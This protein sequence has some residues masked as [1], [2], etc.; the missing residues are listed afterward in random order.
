L[1]SITLVLLPGLEGS[2]ALFANLLPELPKDLKV[3]VRGYP[4][5]E[6]LSYPQLVAWLADIVPKDGPYVLL[7]ES[8]GSP[9]AVMFAATHPPN[10]AGIILSAGFISNPVRRLGILPNLLANPIFS[11]L[12]PPDFAIK[13]FIAGTH[14]P[15]SLLQA[16]RNAQSA[17]NPTVFAKRAQAT[18]HCDA[19][20]EILRVNVPLLYLQGT[21]DHLVHKSALAEIERLHPQTISVPIRAPHLLLQ[22]EP[23]AAAAAITE[24]LAAQGLYKEETL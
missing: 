20:K 3:I 11:R 13:Y 23:C 2:G 17:V 4:Q 1:S 18:L 24:F 22:R 6:F 7:G 15:K 19:R 5:Q 9:L 14:A 8:F 12:H 16:I 21:E 10:L